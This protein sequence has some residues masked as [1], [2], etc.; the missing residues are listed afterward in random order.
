MWLLYSFFRCLIPSEKEGI[1]WRCHF[2]AYISTSQFTHSH[3]L[4]RREKATP[5]SPY[6]NIL[7]LLFSYLVNRYYKY[8]TY[9]NTPFFHTKPSFTL[10]PSPF[11][12]PTGKVCMSYLSVFI[13]EISIF[14][15]ITENLEFQ[16]NVLEI[17]NLGFIQ[18]PVRPQSF[19][20]KGNR[21]LD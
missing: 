4:L 6:C 16:G 15:E 1:V 21:A 19:T 5:F 17:W 13:S 10:S 14:F 12:Y 20:N 9:I 7:L 11:G 2:L 3:P 18:T 8:C